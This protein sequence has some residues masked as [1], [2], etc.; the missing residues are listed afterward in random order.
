[1][2]DTQ[3]KTHHIVFSFD[4]VENVGIDTS[5]LLMKIDG[6]PLGYLNSVELSAKVTER[7]GNLQ[8]TQFRNTRETDDVKDTGIWELH[9]HGN[10]ETN[11]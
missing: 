1:M 11:D 9:S 3:L 8:Y 5:T 6:V 10:A 7:F 4:I 2:P